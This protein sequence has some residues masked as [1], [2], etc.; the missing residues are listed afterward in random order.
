VTPEDT[1]KETSFAR[2]NSEV[3][4]GACSGRYEGLRGAEEVEDLTEVEAALRS[5]L[6]VRSD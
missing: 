4:T 3:Q 5:G 1:L 2:R 6:Q